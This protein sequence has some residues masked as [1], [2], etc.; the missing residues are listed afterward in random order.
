MDNQHTSADVHFASPQW[1][2]PPHVSHPPLSSQARGVLDKIQLNTVDARAVGRAVLNIA[3]HVLVSSMERATASGA[4]SPVPR[5]LAVS[6]TSQWVMATVDRVRVAVSET[7]LPGAPT[8]VL[9]VVDRLTGR[10]TSVSPAQG[11]RRGREAQVCVR[12]WGSTLEVRRRA[13]GVV[14]QK[15]WVLDT[16]LHGCI[17]HKEAERCLAPT[18]GFLCSW[19]RHAFHKPHRGIGYFATWY[20]V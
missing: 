13:T 1:R 10:S 4:T 8:S 6:N 19:Y 20:N 15:H 2:V 5:A 3:A 17:A 11:H 7:L 18:L 14:V 12:A 16:S 9:A